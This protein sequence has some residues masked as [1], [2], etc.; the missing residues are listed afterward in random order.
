[1]TDQF[2]HLTVVLL[3]FM[4]VTVFPSMETFDSS[5][6]SLSAAGPLSEDKNDCLIALEN[7][8]M[9]ISSLELEIS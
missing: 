8:K 7:A 4:I 5:A 1:M 3:C 9:R 6:I 2:A